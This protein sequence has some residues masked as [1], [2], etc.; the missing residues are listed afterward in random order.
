MVSTVNAMPTKNALQAS[1]RTQFA[2][3]HAQPVNKLD[4]IQ[5]DATVR[6]TLIVSQAY[7]VMQISVNQIRLAMM[8]QHIA[9]PIV[10]A[11]LA[12]AYRINASPLATHLRILEPLMMLASAHTT[13]NAYLSIVTLTSTN[14]SPHVPLIQLQMDHLQTTASAHLLLNVDHR[15]ALTMPVFL[16]V[17]PLN[18]MVLMTMA[19]TAHSMQ[20]VSQQFVLI[21]C[22]HQTVNNKLVV[23]TLMDA[24][25]HLAQNV[26]QEFVSKVNVVQTVP[27]QARVLPMLTHAIAHQTLSVNLTSASITIVLPNALQAKPMDNS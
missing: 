5:L 20:N 6:P 16:T 14:V 25:A 24:N 4:S 22:A 23:N 18:L 3:P 21:M 1:V 17:L 19:A 26:L 10:I 2:C 11:A 27:Q 13:L 7:A 9:H 15:L 12:T 8:I